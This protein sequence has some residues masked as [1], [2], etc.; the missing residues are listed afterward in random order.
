MI[1]RLKTILGDFLRQADL[2]LL[3]LCSAATIYGILLIFSATRYKDSNR[4]VIVQTV[5]LL[6]GIMVYIAFSM[7]DLE[8]L[9]KRWKLVAFFNVAFILLLRTPF[10]V[11]AYGNRA[12]LKF[13]FIPIT[14]GPAEVVKITFVLLLG[15]QLAWLLEEKR[16]LKSLRSALSVGV[17]T[18][19]LCGLYVVVSGDMGNALVFF[20]IFLCMAFVAG[21]ALR[22]FVLVLGGGVA[23]VAAAW[24]LNLM[25][26]YMRKRFMVLFDHSYDP[27]DA[28]WQQTRSLL[29]LGSGGVTGQGFLNGVQTQSSYGSSLPAR[30]TDFVFSACGEELGMLGCL[31]VIALLLAII[32]RVLI[33]AKKARSPFECY[34]CVGMAA[35]LIF[36]MTIN[37]GMCLFVMPTIGITLP[38]FSYGGSSVVTLFMAMG[39]VSGIKK[40]SPAARRPGKPLRQ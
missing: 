37:I 24:K 1:N 32:F 31:A 9:M 25:P 36:Q 20:F 23:A 34:V 7:V 17:H 6:L 30:W 18:A 22:W 14:I 8:M 11:E 5:A 29:T 27:M 39:V 28:G 26:T 12:W 10:G 40:R 4:Y 13:P 38:F 21:F 15:W 19:G 33:V 2:V 35:M 16:D 3:G